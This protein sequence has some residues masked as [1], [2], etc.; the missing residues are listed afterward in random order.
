MSTS[1]ISDDPTRRLKKASPVKGLL[2]ISPF[3]LTPPEVRTISLKTSTRTFGD[4]AVFI[5]RIGMFHWKK[6]EIGASRFLIVFALLSLAFGFRFFFGLHCPA[7]IID[8]DE[9]QTYLIGLKSYTTHTWPY[10]GTDMRSGGGEYQ[11]QMAG[12]LEGLLVSIPLWI[13]PTPESPYLFVNILSFLALA[14]WGW[15][16]YK[17]TPGLPPWLLFTWLFIAPWTTHFSTQIMNQSYSLV[18]AILF[19]L[20]LM[21]SLPVLSLGWLS[22]RPANFLMGFG[23]FWLMQLHMSWVMF[24][25][26][27]AYSLYIQWKSGTGKTALGYGILGAIPMLTLLA[28]TYLKYGFTTS[29]NIRGYS[30]LFNYSNMKSFF[31]I[32]SRYLSFASFELPRFIGAN[33]HD[34]C[35]YLMKTPWLAGPGF[36]LW[37][38][39]ILQASS[40]LVLGFFP[41]P[42]RKDWN[43]IRTISLFFFLV[44]YIFFWFSAQPPASYRYYEVLPL[45]MLYSFYCWESLANKTFW[46]IVGVV[47]ITTAVLFQL[48]YAIRN[49]KEGTSV[50]DRYRGRMEKALTHN[51]Y[52]L[53]A[54]RRPYALY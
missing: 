47:F 18:G 12:A 28:P 38:T 40:L 32:L 4:L 43:E 30:S 21:E 42:G 29:E 15:Y 9:I 35:E 53:M 3:Q 20:G 5:T 8:E 26:F 16:C 10:F 44:I 25:P 7:T 36:V 48:G 37:G 22:S 27:L 31:D 24:V 50:Y 49:N 34:R 54:E 52:R 23:F 45:V 41:K 17:R 19:F 39:G 51:D 11:G 46:R 6:N 1:I 33:N 13:W 14:L 2:L